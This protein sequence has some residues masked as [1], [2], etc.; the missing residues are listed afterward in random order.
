MKSRLSEKKTK[1]LGRL[2]GWVVR[3]DHYDLGQDI[4]MSCWK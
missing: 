2:D 1:A 3:S 4:E